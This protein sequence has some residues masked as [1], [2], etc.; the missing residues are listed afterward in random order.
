MILYI[1]LILILI[2]IFLLLCFKNKKEYFN[3]PTYKNIMLDNNKKKLFKIGLD[4]DISIDTEDCYEKC[5]YENCTKMNDMRRELKKCV[6]CNS[7]KNKCFKKSIIG[8]LCD[9]CDSEDKMDCYNV[10]NFGCTDPNNIQYNIG[11][12]PYFVEIND[13]S[14]I[15]PYNKK[16]AFC[17]NLLDSI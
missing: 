9:D 14:V 6:E 4:K 17:W 2:I 11:V 8:G 3:I 10:D 16:C 15:S 12:K 5:D 13:D 1:I 7:Q